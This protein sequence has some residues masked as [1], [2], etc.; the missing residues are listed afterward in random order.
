MDQEATAGAVQP[1]DPSGSGDGQGGNGLYDEILSFAPEETRPD[2]EQVLKRRD[3]D[4]TRKLQDAADL[5][6]QFEPLAGIEGLSDVPADELTELLQFRELASDQEKFADWWTQIGDELG[7]FADGEDGG[8]GDDVDPHTAQLLQR[9]EQLEQRLEPVT[10][11]ITRSEQDRRVQAADEEIGRQLE[12][13]HEQHGEFDDD[14]V[15]ALAYRYAD[16]PDAVT[17]GFEHY[18]R[19]KGG[20][21]GELVDDKLGQPAPAN[22][23]GR[24]DTAPELPKTFGPALREAAMARLAGGA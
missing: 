5:R 13:L 12:T 11:H 15:L 16:D 20:A 2:L 19:I 24:P 4:I 23:A 18:R 22:G 1:T 10:E 8:E 6:K 7:F 14:D 21:Q 17:K 3:A 9:L